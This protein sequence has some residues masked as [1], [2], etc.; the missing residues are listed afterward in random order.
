MIK[1]DK[2]IID[3]L[4]AFNG[5]REVSYRYELLNNK[6]IKVKDLQVL[7]GRIS[8][9]SEAVINRTA[10][11]DVRNVDLLDWL[12]HRIKAYFRLK[13]GNEFKEWPLGIFIPSTGARKKTISNINSI[14]C[15]DANLILSE[16]KTESRYFIASGTPYM[17]AITSIL[18]SAGIWKYDIQSTN[19]TI[20]MDKE[21]ETGT[22]KIDII[23]SLLKEINYTSLWAD[24]NGYFRSQSYLLPTL[25]EVEYEYRTDQKSIILLD[26]RTEETDLFNTPNRWV[27]TASNPEKQVLTASYTNNNPVSKTSTVSRG[28]VITD[29]RQI[30]DI[31]DQTT[32]N[33]YVEKIAYEASSSIY[34]KLTFFTPNM[35]HHTY[36]DCIWI[37]DNYMGIANK[38]IETSWEMDLNNGGK[39]THKLRR[40]VSI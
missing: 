33:S 31:A 14:E 28:R 9:D 38:F 2:N 12:N 26:G 18:N 8:F 40:V 15:Y 16:D 22:S 5:P 19:A 10:S 11:F 13:L 36:Q 17:T 21:Y 35:P 39:M 32:L 34:N 1:L 3:C 25:R 37:E 27:V 30:D 29:F 6:D 7:S 24:E 4:H 20:G 23:N